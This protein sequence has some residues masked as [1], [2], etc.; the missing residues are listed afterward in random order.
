MESRS[1]LACESEQHIKNTFRIW[2]IR[3]N[4][5][6]ERNHLTNNLLSENKF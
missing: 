4:K 5:D 1:Q 6:L 3:P 2:I